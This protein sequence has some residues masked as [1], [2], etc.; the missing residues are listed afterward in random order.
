MNAVD[1]NGWTPVHCAA[2]HGRLG[3]LQ[4][5]LRWGGKIDETDNNGNTPGI[6]DVRLM[7]LVMDEC[8][9]TDLLTY[10]P[11]CLIGFSVYGSPH[12]NDPCHE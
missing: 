5:L 4:L 2:F 7:L 1:K 12:L 3:C 8:N 11:I 10:S 9:K 6:C